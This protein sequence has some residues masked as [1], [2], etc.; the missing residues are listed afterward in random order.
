MRF[1]RTKGLHKPVRLHQ[2]KGKHVLFG[3]RTT[4][5][6]RMMVL[7]TDCEIVHACNILCV[8]WGWRKTW[9]LEF[10]NRV[11]KRK[12][13]A[14][15]HVRTRVTQRGRG[16]GCGANR[17]QQ[18]TRGIFIISRKV[19]FKKSFQAL[20]SCNDICTRVTAVC[21][22]LQLSTFDWRC[23]CGLFRMCNQL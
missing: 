15:H 1:G 18:K 6:S 2:V 9:K 4:A 23:L 19:I 17:F 10:S 21:I 11:L 14:T 3:G 13:L 5:S 20:R 16:G 7:F 8:F 12:L 22:A